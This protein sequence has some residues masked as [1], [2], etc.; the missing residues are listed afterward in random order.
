MKRLGVRVAGGI[1]VV[2]LG[3]LAA[4]QAQKDAGSLTTDLSQEFADLDAAAPIA[5][6]DERP[7][8]SD[9][10]VVRGK[11]A[12]SIVASD[13]VQLASHDEILDESGTDESGTAAPSLSMNFSPAE[14]S[15]N[16]ASDPFSIPVDFAP[17]GQTAPLAA[18]VADDHEASDAQGFGT[19][20]QLAL[21]T[22][23]LAAETPQFQEMD[24]IAS[25][26]AAEPVAGSD[27]A[28]PTL[29]AVSTESQPVSNPPALRQV[30]AGEPHLSAH[31]GLEHTD[32]SSGP[33][34]SFDD[35]RAARTPAA[36]APVPRVASATETMPSEDQVSAVPGDRRWDG[37]QAPSVLIHKRAPAEV[38]V[39]LPA[40]FVIDVR[41]VGATEALNV[42][43][44]DRIPMGMRLVDS[45]PQP[46]IRGELLTWALGGVEPGGERAITIQLVPE[47]E[48]ELGSVARV[49]FEAAASV[50]TIATRPVLK[51]S[52]RAPERVLLGQQLELE[53]EVQNTGTGMA[54][55]VILQADIPE[56]L[57]HP[58]GSQ[59]DNL[60]GNLAPGEIRT[61]ILRLRA[62]NPG[63]VTSAVRLVSNG[64][65]QAEHD[66]QVQVIAPNVAVELLGPSKRFLERQATFNVAIANHGSANATNLELVAYLDRGFTFISTE[67]QGQYDPTNHSVSWSLDELPIGAN[68]TVP[69]TLLPVQ[70][71][72]HALRV[73]VLADLGIRERTEKTVSVATVAEL[74]FDVVDDYDPIETGAET[75][76]TVRISNRGSRD[77]AN[78]Q[79]RLQLP[80]ELELVSAD[81]NA[82]T[83]GQGMVVFEP[84]P[85]LKADQQEI[86]RVRVRGVRPGTHKIQAILTSDQSQVPVIKEESTTVYADQ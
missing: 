85:H 11:D 75:T 28:T 82:G 30:E 44:H 54:R 59:L 32:S 42:Q 86:Y 57:E 8:V 4:A 26:G 2:L 63:Q 19:T 40:T 60:L 80:P 27:L 71:G 69:L 34:E 7:W 23:D 81:R 15:P 49:T 22:L 56:G 21:P 51:I 36:S 78:V 72:Q 70:E 46:Q 5:A 17:Q 55:N 1:G 10:P 62:V 38:Q 68:G 58:K 53:I 33:A 13:A 41:N 20:A 35:P 39:G 37:A 65:T 66:T 73:E 61:Q 3:I 14:E 79:L 76:Y 52:Q 67:N 50:R 47:T 77:D 83:D 43:V 6:S 48:G 25:A 29:P 64:D 24:N 9:V 74:T 16:P 84:M 12:V 45:T 18:D 31:P